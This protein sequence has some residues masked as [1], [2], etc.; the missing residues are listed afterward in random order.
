M[1]K[2]AQI[3]IETA[4]YTLIGI[5]LIG[6]VLG[7]VSPKIQESKDRILLDQTMLSLNNLNKNIDITS[8]NVRVFPVQIKKG[9]LFIDSKE[10]KI[11][12]K[13][14]NILK[15]P[16]EEGYTIENGIVKVLSTKGKKYYSVNL[17]L[18]YKAIFDIKVNNR[19][20]L[21]R[22][23]SAPAPYKLSISNLGKID[24]LNVI[25]IKEIS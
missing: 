8:N 16:T 1:G 13:L 4:L 18:D 19:E 2:K 7:F 23:N 22:L 6:L 5:V 25:D 24:K 17:T 21:L 3:W 14:D 9:E 10:D 20:E 15:A 12:F 11:T